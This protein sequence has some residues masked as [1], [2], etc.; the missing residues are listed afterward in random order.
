MATFIS[1]Q[2]KKTSEVDLAKPL[3]KFIQQTYP[4]GGE[5][6]A[7]YCRAAEELSKLR[8]A[9]L[10][11]PLDKHEGALETLLRYYDQIC[12]IEPKFPFSENQICL[13]FTWKDAFDKGS[14]FGGSVKLALASLGYEKSCVLF[15]CAALASQIAAE[16]NLDNDEGLKIAA[17]HYQFASGAF[18]HIKETV[19]SALNRE[20][21]VDLS[22]DT[23]G[24]LSVIMLA[25][26]QE[27]F[28]LKATRD[29]M[30]DAII[31]KLANQAADYFGDAFKQCQ[32]K[33]TLPKEVFPVLAAKHCIM[34]ANAEYHQSILAKQQKKFGEEIARLQHAAELIKT[35]ASRYDE[36]VSVKDFS[37]KINR[38]LT[39]AKKDN[40]F[41]YHDRVPDLKDL[42]PIGKA[43]LVKPTP[44]SVP[45]SQKFT[46]LFEKMVP[47]SVQQSLAA[48]NQR[49]ADLV[50][51]SIAQMREATTLANGV[52]ASLNLPAAIEDVSGDTVPQSILTKSTSVIEQG[53]IQTV[54][55]LIRELPELLQRNREILDESL[56]LLDE[57]EATDKDLRA[58]FKERWQR[59]PS[60]ELYKP[61]RAE[62]NNFRAV[63]DK[64]VQADGQVKERYQAHRDTIALLCKPEPELN[65]AIPSANPAKTMQGSEVVNVLKSLLTNLDGVK[66]EREGLENDLKAVNFDMTSKFLTALAQDGVINEE[67]L[68]VTELDRVYGGLTSKV[69]E[70]LKK[71]EGLLK[72]I[73]VSHQEFSKMKQSNNEANLREEVLKNLAAAYDSFVELVANLNEGT[74]FYNEL[75]EILVRFQNKCSD[76]VFARKTERDELLKDLQQSIARE[77]SAPAIPTP[78]YQSSP[79]GGHAPT[80]PTPA[81]RTLPV[82]GQSMPSKPQP[83][84]RPPPPVLPA[85]RTPSATAP[86]PGGAGVPAAAPPPAPSSAPPPQAQGPPYPTYPGYPGYCQMPMPMGY[87]PYA[88]GQYNMPY[89]PVYHQNPGQAPYPGPQQPAYPFP[90]PP[91]QS[92]YPQQ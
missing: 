23:V 89:P 77:P 22:P 84:A 71:Q 9:A 61:L 30:K 10:G 44:V 13:T 53:G 2:L 56:R 86:A 68:S 78:A 65:A 41:I 36:Y 91:Q 67:A 21:T 83:P 51:R 82:S 63:L 34:Q 70:S 8:R 32:Y 17:K 59:T 14:L 66:K 28:F 45:I 11:R 69:Q 35:V 50:N 38:A 39:A 19:L 48:Y 55:K 40:D 62:G 81:P 1:V 80:P 58:K 26:A 74:K 64:A 87:N 27:V 16:Q 72:S 73:Q 37:D 20:P 52:L 76:I 49:K 6:Q 33:D 3:V 4:S 25:Q 18:L 54:D 75:T 46:D 92:Y 7:Q 90:Q 29:K 24:T 43:T 88:Y 79:A 31:A 15:N 42:D 47:V 60:S 12:S 57:E 5:E 85:N